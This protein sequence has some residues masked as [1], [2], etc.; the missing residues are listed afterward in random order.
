M[1]HKQSKNWLTTGILFFA[2]AL[3]PTISIAGNNAK[4]SPR[5]HHSNSCGH[6]NRYNRHHD[7]H[8]YGGHGGYY[9]NH[10]A[11]YPIYPARHHYYNRHH[12][13]RFIFGLHDENFGF[14]FYD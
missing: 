5:H 8:Y 6:Y 2:I 10:Y 1:T 13:T 4:H 11:P 14:L 3:I 7:D 9:D 12:D